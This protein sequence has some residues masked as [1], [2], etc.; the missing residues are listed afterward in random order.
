MNEDKLHIA[1]HRAQLAHELLR[2]EL[3]NEAF[4]VIEAEI[5]SAWVNWK[6]D[7]S[8]GR[9]RLWTAVNVG[10]R[11]KTLLEAYIA[12]GK[13]AQRQ[14]EELATGKPASHLRVI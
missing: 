10:R 6:A 12:N 8:N 7:D 3:F 13:V 2:N 9:E 1:V 14:I 4:H 11:Y 5:M